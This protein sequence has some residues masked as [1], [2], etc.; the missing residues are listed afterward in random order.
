MTVL[1]SII[2]IGIET[3]VLDV[4]KTDDV[5]AF[6]SKIDRVDVLFNCAG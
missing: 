1:I 5:K 2:L 4:T 3:H 6:L